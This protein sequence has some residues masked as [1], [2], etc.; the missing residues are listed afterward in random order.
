MQVPFSYQG[1]KFNIAKKICDLIPR[2]TVYVEPYFG[3]GAVFFRKR[4]PLISNNHHYREVLNDLN[5]DI[6]NF[7]RV[8]RD[9]G[10]ELKLKCEL[11]PYSREEYKICKDREN[12]DD[13]E[14]ARRFY[15]S[16]NISFGG[17]LDSGF[18][19]S[20]YGKNNPLSLINKTNLLL[21]FSKRL[22]LAYI[23]NVDAIECIKRWDS[24]Q[25]FFYC[26]PPYPETNQDGYKHKYT[27]FDFEK[28]ID[29]LDSCVGSF[30]LSSYD[31]G[32]YPKNSERFELDTICHISGKGKTFRDGGD[33][34]SKPTQESMG[35]RKRK[36]IL[37]VRGSR[38]DVRKEIQILYDK[39]LYDSFYDSFYDLIES[40]Y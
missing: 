7:F 10:E 28:L 40:D 25:T 16:A 4:Y 39:G 27:I 21:D 30:I 1:G 15:I 18:G 37:Y 33:K 17:K 6:Y 5:S 24:P 35:N 22:R 36:E 3:S 26:D 2:H 34:N 9:R 8:L 29:V 38:I 11:T 20:I 13:L 32:Y 23:E 14:R 31:N 12:C 19:R